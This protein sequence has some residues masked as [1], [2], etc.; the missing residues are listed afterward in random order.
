MDKS[1]NDMIKKAAWSWSART[2]IPFEEF[3]SEGL[4]E[5][6]KCY[7]KYNDASGTKFSTFFYSCL[8]NRL[9]DFAIEWR[10]QIPAIIFHD[11]EDFPEVPVHDL[12]EARLIFKQK[13]QKLS[14]EAQGV[15]DILEV[16]ADEII[17]RAQ[18]SRKSETKIKDPHDRK[19]LRWALRA[20]LLEIGWPKT[21]INKTFAE[22]SVAI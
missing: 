17:L 16:C 9:H 10:K 15:I 12:T 4:L 2:G 21:S 7:A 5:Y 20:F 22:L 3:E 1:V 6:V 8:H 11:A 14:P 18:K 13:I 19:N